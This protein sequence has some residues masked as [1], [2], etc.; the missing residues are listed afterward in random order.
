MSAYRY[1]IRLMGNAVETCEPNR[2]AAIRTARRL[3]AR[4]GKEARI[5][6]RRA[7]IGSPNVWWIG[8]QGNV[9]QMGVR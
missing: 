5:Q 4:H 9:V 2:A 1:T 7:R 8:L 3:M 6:D